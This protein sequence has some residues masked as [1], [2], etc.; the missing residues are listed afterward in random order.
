[1]SHIPCVHLPTKFTPNTELPALFHCTLH[2][3]P[4]SQH[5]LAG[6]IPPLKTVSGETC[7][8]LVCFSHGSNP[9]SL[10]VSGKAGNSAQ[11]CTEPFTRVQVSSSSA[12]LISWAEL[13]MVGTASH[14]VMVIVNNAAMNIECI[15]LFK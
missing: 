8:F 10:S 11:T 1:M 5:Q 3:F 9:H 13:F 14:H 7:I 6:E 12:L 4:P 2:N 15:Y